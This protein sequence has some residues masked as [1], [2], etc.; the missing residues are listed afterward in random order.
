MSVIFRRAHGGR[1]SRC[2]GQLQCQETAPPFMVGFGIDSKWKSS[3]SFSWVL[4]DG[5]FLLQHGDRQ[6]RPVGGWDPASWN[7]LTERL[8]EEAVAVIILTPWDCCYLEIWST[9]SHR[10][11][12]EAPQSDRE[13]AVNT[14]PSFTAF[15][16][17]HCHPL[18]VMVFSWICHCLP[19]IG[20]FIP[21]VKSTDLCNLVLFLPL[22]GFLGF[23]SIPLCLFLCKH[24]TPY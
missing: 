16:R 4:R 23:W 19:L 1:R 5:W 18:F 9:C 14:L 13:T 24:C 21:F 17:N 3:F 10:R 11:N 12:S 15:V 6:Q 8:S 20:L 2:V 7:V 22:K